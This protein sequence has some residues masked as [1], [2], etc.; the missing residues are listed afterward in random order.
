MTLDFSADA[1]AVLP[2]CARQF[3]GDA[4]DALDLAASYRPAVSTPRC[5]PSGRVSIAGLAEI[6]AAGQLRGRS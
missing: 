3:E 4:G 5:W 2:R 6:D 1:H